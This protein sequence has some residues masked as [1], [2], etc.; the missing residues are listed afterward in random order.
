VTFELRGLRRREDVRTSNWRKNRL[1]MGSDGTSLQACSMNDRG[2]KLRFK[3]TSVAGTIERRPVV[4]CSPAAVARR[5]LSCSHRETCTNPVKVSECEENHGEEEE[6]RETKRRGLLRFR[7][8]QISSRRTASS[9]ATT[10]LF[11]LL[12]LT[13]LRRVCCTLDSTRRLARWEGRVFVEA[14]KLG[15]GD[16][17]ARESVE[18]SLCTC[19]ERK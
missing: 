17:Q 2:R 5:Q 6:A 14:V 8:H 19:V 9:A 4:L 12:L 10:R 18:A 11:E 16:Q 7:V 3:S 1:Q 15:K 13:L